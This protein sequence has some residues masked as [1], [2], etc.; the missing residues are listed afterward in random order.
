MIRVNQFKDLI[1]IL[2]VIDLI[3]IIDAFVH[4]LMKHHI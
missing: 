2:A 1:H 4:Q 3:D